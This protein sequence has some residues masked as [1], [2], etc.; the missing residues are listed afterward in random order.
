MKERKNCCPVCGY[1]L[2]ARSD[3]KIFCLRSGC[4]WFVD[5]RRKDDMEKVPEI[6]TLKRLWQ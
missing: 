4:E 5:A 1:K 2:I 6:H 3:N